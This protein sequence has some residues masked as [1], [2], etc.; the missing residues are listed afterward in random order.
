M[1]RGIALSWLFSARLARLPSEIVV[2]L[3]YDVFCWLRKHLPKLARTGST[4]AL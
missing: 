2:E 1:K 3:G 4:L